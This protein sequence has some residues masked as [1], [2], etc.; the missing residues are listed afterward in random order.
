MLA[1]EPGHPGPGPAGVLSI[2]SIQALSK[3]RSLIKSPKDPMSKALL[4]SS[5]FMYG[6]RKVQGGP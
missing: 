1:V 5:H 4:L 3:A 6:E 2:Y